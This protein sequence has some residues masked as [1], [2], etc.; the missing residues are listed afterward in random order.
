M[1]SILDQIGASP[2]PA[3]GVLPLGTGNDLARALGWGG[4]YT[5]EP[6]GKILTNI[7]DSDTTLLDRWELAVE[8]NP[9]AQGDD[10]NGK[11]KENLPLNVVNNYF[12]LGVDAHI[13]L[14]FHEARGES[15][16]SIIRFSALS[17]LAGFSQMACNSLFKLFGNG[18][19]S[20]SFNRRTTLK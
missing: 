12:S 1:L 3:V 15:R 20:V 18:H 4:G 16:R 5:D 13:A 8:R 10:D 19:R 11:G 14:E 2:P 9:D 6:I 17:K 7:G